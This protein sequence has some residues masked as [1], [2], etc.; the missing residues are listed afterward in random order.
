MSTTE[1][2]F[3]RKVSCVGKLFALC[4]VAIPMAASAHTFYVRGSLG[5]SMPVR[6]SRPKVRSFPDLTFPL[7]VYQ[8]NRAKSHGVLGLEF[9]RVIHL[10]SRM[11]DHAALG[12]A[13]KAGRLSQKGTITMLNLPNQYGYRGKIRFLSLLGVARVPLWECMESHTG[14]S[15]YLGAGLSRNRLFG[16]REVLVRDGMLSPREFS[17]KDHTQTKFAYA[18]GLSFHT[19]LKEGLQAV[20][21]LEYFNAGKSAYGKLVRSK[22]VDNSSK[23]PKFDVK[24][25]TVSVGLQY[26]F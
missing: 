9:G 3:V 24:L 22:K 5:Y 25:P 13:I 16:Y 10:H 4:F 20:V 23:G 1:K 12:L 18:L 21:G 19:E 15:A 8:P 26:L 7:D 14:I 2:L 6:S 17:I 11:F